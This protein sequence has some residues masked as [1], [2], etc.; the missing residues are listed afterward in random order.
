MALS[1]L[2]IVDNPRQDVAL[3]AALR[4]PVY[5]FSSDRLAQLRSRS[6]GDFY[7]A[8]SQGALEGEED[9]REFLDQLSQLRFGAGDKTCRQLHLAL[10]YE[11]TN[12][13]GLF[14]YHG[15]GGGAAEQSAGP[16]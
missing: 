7:T 1:I 15:A 8:L 5:G 4:S 13:L 3:L 11:Q 16:V 9:C 6:R 12:I 14:G 2:Q 10:I